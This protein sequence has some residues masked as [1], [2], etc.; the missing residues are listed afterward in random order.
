MAQFD[1]HRN[2]NPSSARA[3]PYLLNIQSDLLDHLV[4]RVVAPLA[5]LDVIG[6]K[7]AR[8]LNPIFEIEGK[9]LAM[10][11][12]ELAGIPAKRLGPTVASLKGAHGEII[13]ALDVIFSGV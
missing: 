1:V 3:V 10:L 2:P 11:T 5:S 8:Y 12:P 7:T 6:N 9:K 4:T 13:R